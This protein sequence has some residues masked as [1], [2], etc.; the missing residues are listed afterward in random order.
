[1][2]HEIGTKAMMAG[3]SALLDVAEAIGAGLAGHTQDLSVGRVCR[4]KDF[5]AAAVRQLW[6]NL[7]EGMVSE[8]LACR[9][10]RDSRFP[11]QT[12]MPNA[13]SAGAA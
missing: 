2:A 1:R 13:A 11:I 6:R 5:N 9:V 7:D 8:Y 3:V 10:R 12:L 4:Q